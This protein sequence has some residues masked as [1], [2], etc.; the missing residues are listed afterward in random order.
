MSVAAAEAFK[1]DPVDSF[2][3]EEDDIFWAAEF[4]GAR[5]ALGQFAPPAISLPPWSRGVPQWPV[6]GSG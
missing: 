6:T 4:A 3:G 1:R 5:A 2:F